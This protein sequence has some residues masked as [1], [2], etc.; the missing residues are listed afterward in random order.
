MKHP[1]AT[2]SLR[3]APALAALALIAA[4]L[5]AFGQAV[6]VGPGT[7]LSNPMGD[8]GFYWSVNNIMDQTGLLTPYTSGVTSVLAY[9]S[10]NPTHLNSFAQT[11]AGSGHTHSW[12]TFTLPPGAITFDLGAIATNLSG[13]YYAQQNYSGHG[14]RQ[15]RHVRLF[16]SGTP[17]FTG[18]PLVWEG[19][20]IAN[21]G[22]I[23]N[24][25]ASPFNFQ[26]FTSVATGRYVKLMIDSN[27]SATPTGTWLA[28]IAFSSGLP[29]IPVPEIAAYDG[30]GTTSPELTDGQAAPVD[31]GS[32]QIPGGTSRT[33][34]LRNAGTVV[35]SVSGVTFSGTHAGDFA[36]TGVPS[37]IAPGATASF[38]V[39]FTPGAVG[40]RGATMNIASNDSDENPFNVPVTGVGTTPDRDGDRIPDDMDNAPDNP[41]PAQED[42]DGDGVGDAADSDDDND[43]VADA[44]DAGP[45]NP[46]SDS[47]GDGLTDLAETTARGFARRQTSCQ[48]RS[49][50][51]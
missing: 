30:P 46:N 43:G 1:P 35:L 2:S 8:L 39:S 26:P 50:P 25:V 42:Y 24:G 31:F 45:L 36:A 12:L 34:T 13:V 48:G 29:V 3:A 37:S 11:P 20:W 51:F 14:S 19:D 47:D 44:Q 32:V 21:G 18:A 27:I 16:V 7:V 33:V 10:S 4:P 9:N 23:G 6:V 22:T 41:N 40:T 5:T 15:I 17:D 49:G 28:E 38:A